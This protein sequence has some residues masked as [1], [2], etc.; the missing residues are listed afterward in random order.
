MA[1]QLINF[2]GYPLQSRLYLWDEENINAHENLLV[3]W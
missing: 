2:R 3:L 1:S